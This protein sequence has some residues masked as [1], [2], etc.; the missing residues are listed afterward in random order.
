MRFFFALLYVM[1]KIFVNFQKQKKHTRS[2]DQ[3]P[4]D[5][6]TTQFFLLCA[7]FALTA[8]CG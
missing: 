2:L 8:A 6:F 5:V 1:N 3:F 4:Q 7:A